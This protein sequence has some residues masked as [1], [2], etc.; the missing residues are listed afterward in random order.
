MTPPTNT[1]LV[2]GGTGKTERRV[3]E[4]L[5]ARGVP[6]RIGSRPQGVKPGAV[7]EP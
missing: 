2:I 6:V 3:A 7:I 4:R 5:I 1:T